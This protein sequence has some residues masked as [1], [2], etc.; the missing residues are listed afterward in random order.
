MNIYNVNYCNITNSPSETLKKPS[1]RSHV[2]VRVV[3]RLRRRGDCERERARAD[4]ESRPPRTHRRRRRCHPPA[5]NAVDGDRHDTGRPVNRTESFRERAAAVRPASSS[6][7]VVVLFR[8]RPRVF[9]SRS[10]VR[11]FF[12]VVH[13]RAPHVHLILVVSRSAIRFINI[14]RLFGCFW[15]CF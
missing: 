8:P 12:V 6:P 7:P 13:S 14:S 1:F 15:N 11:S 4:P 9:A 5:I 3:A 10:C 2:R